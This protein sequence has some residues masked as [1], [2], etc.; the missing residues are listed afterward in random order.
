MN[1]DSMYMEPKVKF[2]EKKKKNQSNSAKGYRKIVCLIVV[3]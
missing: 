1:A 3:F 2:L